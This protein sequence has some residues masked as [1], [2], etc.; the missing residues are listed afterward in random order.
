MNNLKYA[1]LVV[2]AIGA[3]VSL[4]GFI[5]ADFNQFVGGYFLKAIGLVGLLIAGNK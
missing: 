4:I 2:I 3:V 5:G 1:M